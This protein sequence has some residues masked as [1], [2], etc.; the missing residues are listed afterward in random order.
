VAP[1]KGLPVQEF[2]AF[3]MLALNESLLTSG[4]DSMLVAL[5]AF[6]V[7]LAGVFRIDELIATPRNTNR[8]RRPASGFDEEGQPILF[9]PDGRPSGPVAVQK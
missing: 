2:E 5:P 8:A 6:I 9:D 4:L 1:G 7:L 3:V